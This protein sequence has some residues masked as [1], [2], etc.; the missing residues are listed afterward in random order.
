MLAGTTTNF[1]QWQYFKEGQDRVGEKL[2]NA[3]LRLRG[4]SIKIPPQVTFWFLMVLNVSF[5][6]DVGRR[7]DMWFDEVIETM[8]ISTWG[9]AREVLK[10]LIWIDGLHDLKGKAV[11]EIFHLGVK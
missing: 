10:S 5:S 1:L 11:F 4:L 9:E 8:G 3:L 2:I 6:S 7:H